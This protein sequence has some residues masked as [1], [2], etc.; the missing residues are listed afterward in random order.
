MAIVLAEH[1]QSTNQQE[2]NKP[3]QAS[4]PMTMSSQPSSPTSS[5]TVG[6]SGETG[7][8]V[9]PLSYTHANCNS[10]NYDSAK[11]FSQ[12][13]TLNTSTNS[14]FL[15]NV[16]NKE[17]SNLKDTNEMKGDESAQI[18]NK[19]NLDKSNLNFSISNILNKESSLMS[20]FQDNLL[21][22]NFCFK[23]YLSFVWS[24]PN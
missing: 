15:Q 9:F 11:M 21:S 16:L 10:L 17:M 6:P 18:E 19:N 3:K 12:S 1:E 20:N 23:T 2:N 14:L 22:G 8:S 4:T 7:E 5:T 13:K 24:K